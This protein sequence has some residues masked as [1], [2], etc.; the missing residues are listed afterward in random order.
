MARKPRIAPERGNRARPAGVPSDWVIVWRPRPEFAPPAIAAVGRRGSRRRTLAALARGRLR[1]RHRHLLHRRARAGLA[2]RRG[3]GGGLR[4]LRRAVA[5]ASDGIRRD[6]FVAAIACGFAAATIKTAWIAHPI[7][8]F[9]ASGVT[10]AGFVEL[11]EQSQHTDRMVIRVQRIDGDRIEDKPDRVRLSVKRGMA[12]PPGAFVE[13]K[14]LLDPPLQ[15]L[16]PEQLRFCA[17]HVLPGHRRIR[18]RA[19]RHQGR[20]AAGHRHALAAGGR[21][22]S[23]GFAMR[24]TRACAPCCPATKARSRR[25]CSTA[26][27]T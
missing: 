4:D 6:A 14:A 22:R 7:L 25:C 15:P 11:R 18:F 16:A 26:A 20:Y 17:R 1:L 5:P 3:F 8:R 12:P 21:R 24:S 9:N 13:V 2:G 27:A 23:S 10:V 19:R